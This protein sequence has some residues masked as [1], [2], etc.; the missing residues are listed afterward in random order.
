MGF[1]RQ[2]FFSLAIQ[3]F[4][5]VW[6]DVIFFFFYRKIIHRM[7]GF[8]YLFY[9]YTNKRTERKKNAFVSLIKECSRLD[10]M[11]AFSLRMNSSLWRPFDVTSIAADQ[12]KINSIFNLNGLYVVFVYAQTHKVKTIET[13][14]THGT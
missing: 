14:T 5:C 9:V 12:K 4:L 8:W 2:L 6:F 1:F 3:W 13:Y 10:K 11:F 7:N